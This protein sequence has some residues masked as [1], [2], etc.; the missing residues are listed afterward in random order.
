MVETLPAG[1]RVGS[2]HT[3]VS[4]GTAAAAVCCC[5]VLSCVSLAEAEGN[6]CTAEAIKP[7]TTTAAKVTPGTTVNCTRQH[8]LEGS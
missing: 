2:A 3:V 8:G 6:A 5:A 4:E 7:F 1:G